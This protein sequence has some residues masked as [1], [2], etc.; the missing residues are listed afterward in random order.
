[1]EELR[2]CYAAAHA[3]LPLARA[4]HVRGRKHS[5]IL[6]PALV[7]E[8]GILPLVDCGTGATA[9][10]Q[11][12]LRLERDFGEERAADSETEFRKWVSRP[13]EDWLRRDFFK[14][15]I[16]QFKQ[17]PIAW[18][19]VSPGKTYLRPSCSITSSVT[20]Q[21]GARHYSA[22]ARSTLAG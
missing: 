5:P 14:R 20:S 11:I 19:F 2:Q 1:M 4:G 9:A 22:C 18:H 10:Q 13:L 8:D 16:Q 3:R 15:H 7:I 12:R 21:L 17:R 6:G